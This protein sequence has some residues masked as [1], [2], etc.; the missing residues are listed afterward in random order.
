MSSG[1]A[2]TQ[3]KDED[4]V[5][6]CLRGD[7]SAWEALILRYERLIWAVARRSGLGDPDCADVFQHTSLKLLEHL[8]SLRDRKSLAAWR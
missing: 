3:L 8:G 7:R 1:T 2:F 6:L 4:L 5:S